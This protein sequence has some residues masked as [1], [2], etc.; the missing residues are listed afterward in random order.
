MRKG[1]QLGL[2]IALGAIVALVMWSFLSS[3][4][5][6]EVSAESVPLPTSDPDVT[7]SVANVVSPDQARSTTEDDSRVAAASDND[8]AA[9][10]PSLGEPNALAPGVD[11]RAAADLA[12]SARRNAAE[13]TATADDLKERPLG[14]CFRTRSGRE[15]WLAVSPPGEPPHQLRSDS[16]VVWNGARSAWLGTEATADFRANTDIMWQTIDAA[17][18]RGARIELSAQLQNRTS[19]AGGVHLF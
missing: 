17:P 16:R 3:G 2:L 11:S 4:Q 13:F 18:F 12:S 14:W 5:S 8:G 7:Q 9:I 15:D 6:L 1:T 19:P 10:L